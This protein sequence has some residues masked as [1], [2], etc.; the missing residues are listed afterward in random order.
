MTDFFLVPTIILVF[1]FTPGKLE[2]LN[3]KCPSVVFQ[4]YHVCAK[5]TSGT[6]FTKDNYPVTANMYTKRKE[7]WSSSENTYF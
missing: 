7:L 5:C 1:Y 6:S 3:S 4:Y 2:L